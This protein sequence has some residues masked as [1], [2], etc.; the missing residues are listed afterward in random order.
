MN[1]SEFWEGRWASGQTGWD[2]G[3]AAPAL[4]EYFKAIENRDAFILIPGCGNAYEAEWLF[5]NGFRNVYLID[6]APSAIERICARIPAFP[7]SQL[8]CGDFFSV[9]I[10]KFDYI[11]EQTFLCAIDPRFRLDYAHRMFETLKTDGVLAGLLFNC[12]FE[13]GPPFGGSEEEYRALFE[14]LFSIKNMKVTNLSIPPR[15]GRELFFELTPR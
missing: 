8:I 5:E 2:I 3:S 15:A 12:T 4:I 14:P 13:G 1:N 6:I 10:P 9:D 11:I 7:E